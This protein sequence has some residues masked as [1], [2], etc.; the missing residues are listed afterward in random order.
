[1]TG[2]FYDG[3]NTSGA[4][5]MAGGSPCFFFH[6]SVAATSGERRSWYIFR[7]GKA[8]EVAIP[9]EAGNIYDLR[10]DGGE[11][12]IAASMDKYNSS[13]VLVRGNKM[14]A[15]S[16]S[17]DEK[18]SYCR[19][20]SSGG[21]LFIKAQTERPRPHSGIMYMGGSTLWNADGSAAASGM[22]LYVYD[23]YLDGGTAGY[24]S[25]RGGRSL[26]LAAVGTKTYRLPFGYGLMDPYCA[27]IVDGSFYAAL[28]P[29]TEGAGAKLWKNG[30][31]R[32]LDLTN[33]YLTGINVIY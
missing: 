10:T 24:I 7:D 32:D 3:A 9:E 4:I 11:I 18:V 8:E 5:Q 12:A 20:L 27:C 25:G 2:G 26:T 19:L 15:L 21:K 28:S 16:Q 22:G 23:Y 13:L 29:G 17:S 14:T 1:V 33:G 6:T 31:L 30:R